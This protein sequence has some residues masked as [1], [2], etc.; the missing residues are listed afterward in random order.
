MPN[1]SSV[2]VGAMVAEGPPAGV[3]EGDGEEVGTGVAV[4]AP[5]GDA[6]GGSA[7]VGDGGGASVRE[8]EGVEPR[9]VAPTGVVGVGVGSNVCVGGA[10][11]SG[12]A[13]AVSS[14][15]PTST[16]V[17]QRNRIGGILSQRPGRT[18]YS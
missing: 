1:N 3:G 11:G 6:G 12:W 17:T 2:G 8:G 15:T 16:M 14:P 5:G 9:R 10:V 18:S 7:V 13:Q 4:A